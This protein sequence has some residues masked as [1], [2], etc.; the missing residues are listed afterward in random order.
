MSGSNREETFHL[1]RLSG[2]RTDEGLQPC[3]TSSVSS[4]EN[5]QELR[6]NGHTKITIP[7]R[8]PLGCYD[9]DGKDQ[10]LQQ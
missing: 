3:S 4:R 8:C 7:D 5:Q 9:N 2:I 10:G 6:S 1:E